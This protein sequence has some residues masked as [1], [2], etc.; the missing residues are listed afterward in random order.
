MKFKIKLE[1]LLNNFKK[2]L[3]YKLDEEDSIDIIRQIL[4]TKLLLSY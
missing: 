3:N 1:I 2:I 4:Y